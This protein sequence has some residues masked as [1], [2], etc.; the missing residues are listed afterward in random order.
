MLDDTRAEG[1]ESVRSFSRQLHSGLCRIAESIA[2]D[3]RVTIV[4]CSS[5]D[6]SEP[7]AAYAQSKY[8]IPVR[9]TGADIDAALERLVAELVMQEPMRR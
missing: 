9:V 8:C 1:V 3:G 4:I 2:L 7:V 6:E 5:L